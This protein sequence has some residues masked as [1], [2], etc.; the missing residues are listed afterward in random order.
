MKVLI[1]SIDQVVPIKNKDTLPIAGSALENEPIL[2][3]GFGNINPKYLF[4]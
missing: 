4:R 1:R 3:Q 2:H